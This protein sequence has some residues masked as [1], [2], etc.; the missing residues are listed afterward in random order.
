MAQNPDGTRGFSEHHPMILIRNVYYHPL[1]D[2]RDLVEIIASDNR[3]YF[4]EKLAYDGNQILVRCDCGDH[5]FRFAY[6]NHLDHSLYGRKPKKYESLGI[7][8]PANPMQ[9]PGMCK[10]LMKLFSALGHAG[11]IV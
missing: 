10:H 11:V 3:Q 8:P 2:Q 5:R 4:I 6:Y 9:L 1:R 7:G